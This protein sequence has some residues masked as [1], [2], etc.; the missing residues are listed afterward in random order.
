MQVYVSG[1][2]TLCFFYHDFEATENEEDAAMPEQQKLYKFLAES[3][4]YF[5]RIV[6]NCV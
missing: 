4:A 3:F 1:V 6:S 5:I 2:N